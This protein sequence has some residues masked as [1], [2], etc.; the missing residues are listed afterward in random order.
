[1]QLSVTSL[2]A[3]SSLPIQ[4]TSMNL[5]AQLGIKLSVLVAGLIGGIVSLTYETKLSF[6]RALL[7]IVGGAST[8]A[9][10]H[11]LAEHYLSMDS[12]FSS[13]IG[14]V[15]GLVSMKVINFLI[16]NTEGVLNKYFTVNGDPKRNS[17]KPEH[18]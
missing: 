16:A 15:L 10:L 2:L 14:F 9:Y 17:S 7:L 11:P 18:D 13:G 3:V 1:M 6:M 8:A 4:K 12:K 5:E